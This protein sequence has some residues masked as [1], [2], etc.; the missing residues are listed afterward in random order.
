MK[1]IL[2]F[3]FIILFSINLFASGPQG[4][5]TGTPSSVTVGATSTLVLS[6]DIYR[7]E[8]LLINDSNEVIY[9]S[10][11]GTS[12]EMNKGI[13]LNA[14]GGSATWEYS[15]IPHKAIYAICTS[16]NKNLCVQIGQ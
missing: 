9:I 8:I 1:I 4:L 7:E 10:Y 14:N 5:Q 3:I 6:A 2:S 13:R 15:V 12:A 11:G 16:G